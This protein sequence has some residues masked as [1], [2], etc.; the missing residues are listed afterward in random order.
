MTIM[1]MWNAVTKLGKLSEYR[2]EHKDDP[3][4]PETTAAEFAELHDQYFQMFQD[5][6]EDLHYYFS[7]QMEDTHER[8]ARYIEKLKADVDKAGLVDDN[9][10]Y[11]WEGGYKAK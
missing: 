4:E 1:G 10:R 6:I 7:Q 5:Q 11:P 3:A 8:R 2:E 9:G